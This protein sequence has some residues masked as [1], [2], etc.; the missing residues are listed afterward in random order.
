MADPR[1]FLKIRRADTPKRPA[2]ERVKD[3]SEITLP[4]LE[5]K[6]LDQA[7]RCMNCGVPFCHQGCPLGNNVPTWNN[8]VHEGKWREAYEELSKTNPFPE[9]TGKLC[10]APCE[11]ACVLKINDDPVTIK[12]I[13]WSIIERA[14]REGW[15]VPETPSVLT[16]MS[17]GVIGSGPAGL[18]AAFEL[19]RVGH[20][21]TVIERSDRV[22]G[23]IRYGVPDY[24]M[25]KSLIDDRV[26]QLEG[27]GILFRLDTEVGID[28]SFSEIRSEFDAILLSVGALKPRMLDVK[29]HDLPGVGLAMTY[30]TAQNRNLDSGV[31]IPEEWNAEGKDIVILGGGDTGADCYG[32]A[33]RQGA[34]SV[35]QFDHYPDPNVFQPPRKWP[36]PVLRSRISPVHEE[37]GKREW[38]IQTTSV[39]GSTHVTGL[40][41]CEVR[42]DGHLKIPVPGTER[43]I[44][45]DLVLLAIGFVGAEAEGFGVEMSRGKVKIDKRYRTE[46]PGV[47]AAGD[48][49][50]G[51][52]L[53]VWAIADGRNAA[54]EIDLYLRGKS[55]ITR[56]FYS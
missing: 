12:S 32:T 24:K 8:L 40:R 19:R 31:P 17:V 49:S 5:I 48:A 38:S 9:F 36:E 15:V 44:P 53:I 22:G 27:M 54:R 43:V 2:A 25:K 33:I 45:A 56:A 51:A 18:A 47:F 55:S 20:E 50:R 3:W 21:V 35:T 4:L 6:S 13:E 28:V 14:A 11:D 29:G 52:S 30:L 37:G 41:T 26:R 46:I 42:I 1:G 23:L 16:G 34:A 10:P 39:E 7:A